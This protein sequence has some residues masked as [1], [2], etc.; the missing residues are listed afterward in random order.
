MPIPKY[1]ELYM[2]FLSAVIDGEVHT[3]KEIKSAVSSSLN[4]SEAD[5][6]ER[7]SSGQTVFD[8][9]LGWSRLYLKKPD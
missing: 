4:L 3:L 9:R 1:Y 5:L 6:S 2:P 7:I 8:N